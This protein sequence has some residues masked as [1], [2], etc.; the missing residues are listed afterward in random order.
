VKGL[1]IELA[2]KKMVQPPNN[3][4][5]SQSIGPGNNLTSELRRRLMNITL[6]KLHLRNC[7]ETQINLSLDHRQAEKN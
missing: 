5:V 6:Q 2:K 7:S 1:A 4:F 3:L